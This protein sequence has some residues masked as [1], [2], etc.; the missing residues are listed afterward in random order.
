MVH[1]DLSVSRCMHVEL[2]CIGGELQR[3]HE[4]GQRI[5]RERGVRASVRNAF[6]S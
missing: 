2:Y 6:W 1:D 4:R 3:A 5:F